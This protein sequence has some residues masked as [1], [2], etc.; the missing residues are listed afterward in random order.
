MLKHAN[1]AKDRKTPFHGDNTGSN[2]VGDANKSFSLLIG[3]NIL[4]REV[5]ERFKSLLLSSNANRLQTGDCGHLPGS[6]NTYNPDVQA[7][8]CRVATQRC[9]YFWIADQGVVC[10]RR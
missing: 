10:K 4:K 2:P 3:S 6:R 9:D 7:L 5:L 8:Y 1:T